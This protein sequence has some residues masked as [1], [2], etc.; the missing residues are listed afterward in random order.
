MKVQDKQLIRRICSSPIYILLMIF[1]LCC[2]S[3]QHYSFKVPFTVV[4]VFLRPNI[5][6]FL[7]L[8]IYNDMHIKEILAIGPVMWSHIN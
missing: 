7:M 6:I 1:S 4:V 2:G 3:F 5:Y 8:C